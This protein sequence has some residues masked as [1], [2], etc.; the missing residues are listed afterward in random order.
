MDK[1]QYKVVLV[2]PAASWF[3]GNDLAF[4]SSRLNNLEAVTP[5]WLTLKNPGDKEYCFD[6]LNVLTQFSNYDVRVEHPIL[7]FYTND[8]TQVEKLTAVDPLRVK[9]ISMPNKQYPHLT[10]GTVIVKNLDF[11]YKVYLGRTRKPFVEFIA[12]AVNNKKMRLTN[13]AKED[14]SR[15]NSWGGSY[16]YVKG[17]QTLT[18]VKMFVGGEI[19]KIETIIKA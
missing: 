8:G 11:D 13:K 15:T 19:S 5:P 14:L 7:N 3:R 10:K 17:D 4:V 1:Y 9:Y 18:M 2:C 16:F 6:L 12:W